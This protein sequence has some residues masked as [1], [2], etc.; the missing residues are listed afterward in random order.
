MADPENPM[1]TTDAHRD[2][3]ADPA[4]EWDRR[5]PAVHNHGPEDGPGLSC[6]ERVVGGRRIGDCITT[7]ATAG[8]TEEDWR[9]IVDL[10]HTKVDSHPDAAAIAAFAEDQAVARR[11]RVAAT[12]VEVLAAHQIV[13]Y[14]VDCECGWQG[15][16]RSGGVAQRTA[17][18]AHVLDA[19]TTAGMTII[20]L[21][22][23]DAHFKLSGA[24]CDPSDGYTAVF[25]RTPIHFVS[26]KSLRE[27]GQPESL[28]ALAVALLA[29]AAAETGGKA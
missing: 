10:L 19:L 15:D 29:A 5:R 28:R 23:H 12:P 25:I 21:P 3:G 17:H 8:E 14:G 18:A 16:L 4:D 22:E 1:T 9:C 7:P 27:L 11:V 20:E 6:P 24:E 2:P 26:G 13:P